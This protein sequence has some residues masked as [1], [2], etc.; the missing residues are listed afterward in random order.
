MKEVQV[1]C[2]KENIV[3]NGYH[4]CLFVK[5][6]LGLTEFSNLAEFL[7]KYDRSEDQLVYV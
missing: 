3:R 5:K 4:G 6:P 1:I 7:G 2:D